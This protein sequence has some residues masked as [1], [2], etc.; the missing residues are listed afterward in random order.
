MTMQN[1]NLY[2]E[3]FR[4]RRIPWRFE[5]FLLMSLALGIGT[6]GWFALEKSRLDD[7]AET[8]DRYEQQLALWDSRMTQLETQ[9]AKVNSPGQAQL[10]GRLTDELRASRKLSRYFETDVPDEAPVFSEFLDALARRHQDGMWLTAIEILSGGEQLRLS[11][12]ALNPK[13]VPD[14]LLALSQELAYA[15]RTFSS[16]LVN[17]EEAEAWKVDFELSTAR[18]ENGS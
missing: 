6:V 7:L 5:R 11:G 2:Q 12:S 9:L 1:V 3:Q 14:F 4:P 8:R 17:R 18:E 16:L 15:G 13:T 10:V